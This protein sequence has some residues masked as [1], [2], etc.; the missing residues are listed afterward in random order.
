MVVSHR[1]GQPD[2]GWKIVVHCKGYEKNLSECQQHIHKIMT[3]DVFISC[4]NTGAKT[5]LVNEYCSV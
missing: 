2:E 4:N 5:L 3:R 1:Y